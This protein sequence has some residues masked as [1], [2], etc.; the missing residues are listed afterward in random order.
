M[1]PKLNNN[2]NP[3]D[4]MW[5][6]SQDS[7]GRGSLVCIASV[8][9]GRISGETLFQNNKQ[10][11]KQTHIGTQSTKQNEIEKDFDLISFTGQVI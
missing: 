9:P 2:K 11:K 3:L 1:K 10:A 4:M 6:L 5:A 8:Q 7:G